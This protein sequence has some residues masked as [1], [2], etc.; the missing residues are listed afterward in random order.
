MS[1]TFI[2]KNIKLSLEFDSYI[3][4]RPDILA[5]LPNKA[6]IVFTV[7]GDE[8]FNKNSLALAEKIRTRGRKIIEVKKV[9]NRWILQQLVAA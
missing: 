9:G 4:R 5:K 8:A 6:V 7:K 1:K 3:S 2:N